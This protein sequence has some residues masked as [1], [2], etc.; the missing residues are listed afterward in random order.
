MIYPEN[1]ENKI[2]FDRIRKLLSEKCLSPMGA[3]KADSI[4]F[5]DD[6]DILSHNLSATYEFQQLLQ[7]EDFFP[8]DH[9]YKISDCLVKIRIAGN[10][11]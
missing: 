10:I 4:S 7:F 1:F 11:S 5:I 3:E 2:G 6:F 8:S 9:Y